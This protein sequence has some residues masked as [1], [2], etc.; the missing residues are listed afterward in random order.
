[1]QLTITIPQYTKSERSNSFLSNFAILLLFTAFLHHAFFCLVNTHVLSLSRSALVLTELSLL[2]VTSFFFIRNVA[3][4]YLLLLIFIVANTMLLAV[5]QGGFDPKNIRNFALPILMVWLGARYDNRIPV[6]NVLKWLAWIFIIFG[7]FELI[8]IDFFQELFNVLKFQHA[9][10]RSET[11]EI[12]YINGSFSANG[13]RYNGRNFLGF[14]GNHRVASVFLETVNTSNFSTLL[15]AW[16]L[17]KRSIKDGWQ[18]YAIG[19]TVALLADSRFGMTLITLMTLLR[20]CLNVELLKLVS[21]F[22]PIFT[23]VVCVYFGWDY[24]DFKDDFETRLGSTGHYILN[25]KISEFFGLSA[26]HYKAFVDQGYAR[27]LHYN[28]I[29]LMLVLWLSLCR[30][31]VSEQGVL[32]KCFIAVIIGA[33]LAIS[34]DSVFAF[35]WA[36][37]MWFLLGA[38]ALKTNALGK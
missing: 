10:G 3:M 35:K 26:L 29:V 30:F 17:S 18:F 25:F 15:V 13:Q 33:N 16:G 8:F 36:A 5:F 21:Y 34:G 7:L 28:G 11:A 38:T 37:I 19:F 12:D 22:F 32:F 1:M 4:G 20:F 9:M 6:D 31:K 27:L 23:L 14:L 24:T 2:S